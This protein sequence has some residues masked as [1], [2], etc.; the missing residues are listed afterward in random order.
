MGKEL[1]DLWAE[2][3]L[4]LFDNKN[5]LKLGKMTFFCWFVC[6]HIYPSTNFVIQGFGLAHD[7]AMIRESLPALASIKATGQGYMD[8]LNLWRKLTKEHCF[9]FP[10]KGD[11]NFTNESLSKLV[12]LCMGQ[13][14]NKSDQFSNW[15]RRPLRESQLVY[16]GEIWIRVL[17]YL[18]IW[19]LPSLAR[20]EYKLDLIISA[21]DAYCLLEIFQVLRAQCVRLDVAF[22]EVCAETQHIAQKLPKKHPKK[23]A[24]KVWHT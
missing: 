6:T 24:S 17:V 22:N 18:G 16:A 2:L 7:I 3:G 4:I 14:L 5:I 12:E 19:H 11:K 21:L 20:F 13:R 15:E 10:H 9:Q 1:T 23:H 8:L